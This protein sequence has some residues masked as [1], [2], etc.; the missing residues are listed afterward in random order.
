MSL[1]ILARSAAFAGILL[2][3]QASAA[4]YDYSFEDS[5]VAPGSYLYADD[6]KQFSPGG[7][8]VVDPGVTFSGTSGVQSNGSEWGFPP[9][10]NGNYGAFLQNFFTAAPGEIDLDV[11]SLTVGATYTLSF[12]IAQR[13]AYGVEPFNLSLGADDLGAFT[14]TS[15]TWTKETLSFVDNGAAT[16]D[17]KGLNEGAKDVSVGLDAVSIS[18]VGA[19]PELSTWGMMIAG[20]TGLFLVG[21]RRRKLALNGV[22]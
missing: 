6:T 14:A 18:G 13:P 21:G 5:N 8:A 11:S 22:S 15:T 1:G 7:I 3:S 10:P 2:S 19:I 17:F 20:A 9:V 16:L 12:Y 4:V